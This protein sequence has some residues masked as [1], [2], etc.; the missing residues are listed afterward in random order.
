MTR[1][2]LLCFALSLVGGCDLLLDFDKLRDGHGD[3]GAHKGGDGGACTPAVAPVQCK[4]TSGGPFFDKTSFFTLPLPAAGVTTTS[5]AVQD[6]DGDGL[7]DLVFGATDGNVYAWTHTAARTFSQ[8]SGQPCGCPMTT[9]SPT[10][11]SYVDSLSVGDFNGDHITD[12]AYDCLDGTGARVEAAMVFL[13]GTSCHAAT[14]GTGSQFVNPVKYPFIGSALDVDGDGTDD[15][16]MTDGMSGKVYV[17][18]GGGS[19]LLTQMGTSMVSTGIVA[20][21][22]SHA[23][24]GDDSIEDLVVAVDGSQSGQPSYQ[25]LRRGR[26]TG[27]E[28]TLS[29][30]STDLVTVTGGNQPYG[31]GFG[32]VDDD[33]SADLVGIEN[34]LDAPGVIRVYLGATA[35][36]ITGFNTSTTYGLDAQPNFMAIRDL[37]CDDFA[38]V[39]VTH[40]GSDGFEVWQANSAG[41]LTR[42]LDYNNVGA[43]SE[44]EQ[45][46]IADLDQD[47]YADIVMAV[48]DSSGTSYIRI[49]WG[50]PLP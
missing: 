31:C 27:A 9:V 39:V 3:G 42:V 28:R 13:P 18:W 23:G 43:T 20:W 47:G 45:V 34:V 6:F 19:D 50:M 41:V 33:G 35:A 29:S 38:D 1:L 5:L 44:A 11:P 48:N 21:T 40:L 22:I 25:I 4:T 12:L 36:G 8:S 7:P 15:F 24:L 32:F 17:F 10:T 37:N 46:S 26:G 49:A 14:F 16:I 30:A 2:T